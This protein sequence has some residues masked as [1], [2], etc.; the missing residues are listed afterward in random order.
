MRLLTLPRRRILS[1]LVCASVLVA[2]FAFAAAV[3]PVART[4]ST[5]RTTSSAVIAS[6]CISSESV[7]YSSS[8]SAL[9]V[10]QGS[11]PGLRAGMK[12]APST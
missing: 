10:F 3:P 2:S 1:G 6:I 8:Y 12:P 5:I 4:S 7:P 9:V 11:L